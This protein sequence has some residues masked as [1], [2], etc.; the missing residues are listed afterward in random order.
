M[1]GFSPAAAPP[2][3][4]QYAAE[5][6]QSADGLEILL[7]IRTTSAVADKNHIRRLKGFDYIFIWYL[8]PRY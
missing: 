2:D 6:K 5:E 1:A 8:A 3:S 7:A 4:G